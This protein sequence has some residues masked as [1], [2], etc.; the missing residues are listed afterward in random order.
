[1]AEWEQIFDEEPA[2]LLRHDATDRAGVVSAIAEVIRYMVS[3]TAEDGSEDREALFV[4]VNATNGHARF[5]WW[6]LDESSAGEWSYTLELPQLWELSLEHDEGASFFDETCVEAFFDAHEA[7]LSGMGAWFR[8]E[9]GG[10][11][12]H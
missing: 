11:Q 10:L 4:S 1:M 8:T 3:R 5:S 6:K 7:S 2:L 12:K 9:V